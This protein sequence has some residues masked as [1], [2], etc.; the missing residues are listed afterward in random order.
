MSFDS[1]KNQLDELDLLVGSTVAGKYH[2]DRLI[3]RGGMGAVFQATNAAI[4]KR[5][6]LKFLGAETSK[7][8]DASTRFQ[9]EAEAASLA[10]SPHIVQIFDSGR[11]ERGLPFLVME[12]LTG[13]DLRARLRQEGRLQPETAAR[14]ALQVLKALRQAHA[15]GIVHRDLKPD[16]VFLCRRD[17]EPA[18]VKIVDFGI[19]KLQ[20]SPGV[21]TLTHKGA[22]L[23]TAFYMSPE[24]A[25]SFSDIDGR[26][27][28]FSVGAI[29]YEMLTGEPPHSAPTYEAVLIAICTRD[30]EDVRKKAPEVP[31]KLARV[32]A[33]A[34]RRDRDERYQT[35][36]EMLDDLD[37][38]LR[39][40]RALAQ[41]TRTTGGVWVEAPKSQGAVD[42]FRTLV[43]AIVAAL[44]GFAV[45]AYFV[46]R[47]A[48]APADPVPGPKAAAV[49]TA[50]A[51]QPVTVAPEPSASVGAPP[52][53][54]D[55]SKPPPGKLT[56]GPGKKPAPAGSAGVAGGLGLSTR[57]P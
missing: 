15:A 22:V 38:A 54:A 52:A 11:S 7:D 56:K 27:D 31:E 24:Q 39:E 9:R 49:P 4:G 29:M 25:Q 51:P 36:Q 23:G 2:I 37:A 45:A 30:A 55:A 19:S 46:A 28:L 6:A 8:V 57:E 34:L 41:K 13:E 43:F 14:I 21:D 33:R 47:G 53:S 3:G 48:A 17:D 1:G 12:L 5:V 26:T 32:I 20:Q 35:A 50:V 44:G 42:R 40:S 10:E 16:N 18:F